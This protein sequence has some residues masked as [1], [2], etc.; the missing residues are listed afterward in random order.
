MTMR[1]NELIYTGMGLGTCV[2]GGFRRPAR[3]SCPQHTAS[4]S[5]PAVKPCHSPFA[6]PVSYALPLPLLSLHGVLVDAFPSAR[7][8]INAV[9]VVR[10][11]T[12]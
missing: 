10:A 6:S 8:P 5:V 2:A 4:G 7:S 3:A 11:V 1:D 9:S 12:G